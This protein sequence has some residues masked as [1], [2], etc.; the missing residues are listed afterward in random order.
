MF[1]DVFK[2][3]PLLTDE[4]YCNFLLVLSNITLKNIDNVE[5][6]ELLS[7]IYWFTI[8]F[9]LIKKNQTK[10]YDTGIISSSGE[11]K[12]SLS[13]KPTHHLFDLI[14]VLNTPFL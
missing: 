11:T 3:I 10:I 14:T 4:S 2:H 1:N 8:G 7:R 13:Y 9:G 12:Y 6:V 5:V